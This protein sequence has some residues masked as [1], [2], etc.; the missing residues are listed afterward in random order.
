M[1]ERNSVYVYKGLTLEEFRGAI[2]SVATELKGQIAWDEHPQP[3]SAG[4]LTSHHGRVHA[5]YFSQGDFEFAKR[6]GSRV[7]GPWI[8][9]RIQE[10]SLWDYSL[11]QGPAHVQNFSTW[12]E[13]WGE[14]DR[15]WLQAQRGNAAQLAEIWQ[16]EPAN[17][18]NY[19]LPWKY[20]SLRRG[21]MRVARRGKAYEQDQFEYGDIWQMTDFLRALGAHDPNFSEP[22]SIARSMTIPKSAAT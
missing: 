8:N 14:T 19:L 21:G 9:V 2:E 10:G 4:L 16:I 5:A 11:Y 6:V 1:G 13:Y 12:P 3:F 15:K 18:A 20:R 7:D 22:N 17:I